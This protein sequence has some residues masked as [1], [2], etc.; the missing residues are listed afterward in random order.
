MPAAPLPSNEPRRLNRLKAL[1]VL[2]S[3]P[4]AYSESVSA[5]AAAI[6]NTPISAISLVDAERQWFK[7]ACGLDVDE[8]P[9]DVSFCAYA[10][11]RPEPFIVSDTRVDER[12]RDNPLVTGEPFIRFYAGFP[13]VVNGVS[14]GALC[15]IDDHPR[16]LSP[17]QVSRLTS[18]AD[19]TA[20]WLTDYQLRCG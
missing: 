15:V 6:A 20:A 8:T 11:L 12:F 19:G 16:E 10:I 3:M 13:L 9:R 5:A 1:H 4:E 7:G 2:D 18:L 14:I 17:S